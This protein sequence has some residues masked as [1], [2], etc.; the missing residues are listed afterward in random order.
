MKLKPARCFPLRQCLIA[1]I[2]CS[3]MSWLATTAGAQTA[4]Q[5]EDMQ[6]GKACNTPYT[7]TGWSTEHLML[8]GKMA[9]FTQETELAQSGAA[10]QRAI[11]HHGS[12]G[13]GHQTGQPVDRILI[14]Y[15]RNRTLVNL[16]PHSHMGTMNTMPALHAADSNSF[17]KVTQT[18]LGSISVGG[19]TAPGERTVIS[20]RIKA[21]DGKSVEVTS[22][23]DSWYS[24]ELCWPL[25]IE[26]HDSQGH[27]SIVTLEDVKK[28]EPPA[29]LFKI[30]HDYTVTKY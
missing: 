13:T 25:K 2:A 18:K 27:T 28:G 11:V 7:A 22:T 10:Q 19:F 12:P 4:E 3:T 5:S 17:L 8:G 16:D 23:A 24:E 21:A 20:Y 15:W 26:S 30:P 14:T 1:A 6:S 9:D 29:D